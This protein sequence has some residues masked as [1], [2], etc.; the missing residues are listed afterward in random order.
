MSDKRLIL[1]FHCYAV[2]NAEK[3]SMLNALYYTSR[4]EARVHPGTL[5]YI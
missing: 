4:N 5:N 2:S 1:W 3:T